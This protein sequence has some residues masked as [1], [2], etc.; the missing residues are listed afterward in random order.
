MVGG[1]VEKRCEGIGR[2]CVVGSG[3]AVVGEGARV[4]VVV[5]VAEETSMVP[6]SVYWSRMRAAKEGMYA[7]SIMAK[8]CGWLKLRLWLVGWVARGAW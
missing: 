8:A 1:M 5:G 2:A 3:R 6:G 4:C 7:L